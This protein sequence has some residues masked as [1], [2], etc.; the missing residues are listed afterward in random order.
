MDRRPIK[1]P[2]FPLPYGRQV[3][4]HPPMTD[5][6]APKIAG[7]DGRPS[8]ETIDKRCRQASEEMVGN[9]PTG[10][11]AGRKGSVPLLGLE[12]TNIEKSGQNPEMDEDT[13]P[14]HPTS[15]LLG[16]ICSQHSETLGKSSQRRSSKRVCYDSLLRFEVDS[17][18]LK[19]CET[20]RNRPRGCYLASNARWVRS[21]SANSNRLMA[22]IKAPTRWPFP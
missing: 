3:R 6:N 1:R 21:T 2:I 20:I 18:D 15:P 4:D 13:N 12:L 11:S 19:S 14:N 5:E 7:Y 8:S 17:P 22:S 10:P 16:T 9:D